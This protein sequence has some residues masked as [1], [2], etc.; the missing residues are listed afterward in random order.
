MPWNPVKSRFV[1][2]HLTGSLSR[3]ISGF[4]VDANGVKQ[5]LPATWN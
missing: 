5:A 4:H 1:L 3:R 2:V